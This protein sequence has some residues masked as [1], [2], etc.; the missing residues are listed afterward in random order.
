MSVQ[1]F[2]SELET[3]LAERALHRLMVAY[4]RGV[5]RTDQALLETIFHPDAEVVTGA[6]NC[7]GAEFP[8]KITAFLGANVERCMHAVVSEWFEVNGDRATGEAYVIAT[9]LAGGEQTAVGGRY[10]NKFERRAGVWKISQHIFVLDWTGLL[11]LPAN[12]GEMF[13]AMPY[14]GRF[15]QDDP[16]Y[17]LLG[18]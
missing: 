15:G 11:P 3:L 9:T 13:A 4:A 10:M 5:D 8:A 17:S 1:P 2:A 12:S 18:L 7:S 16:V 14:R 6:V